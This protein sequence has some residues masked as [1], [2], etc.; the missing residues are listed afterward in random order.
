MVQAPIYHSSWHHGFTDWDMRRLLLLLVA[1]SALCA[2][3]INDGNK[4]TTDINATNVDAELANLIDI[5]WE[6][7]GL[8]TGIPYFNA[9]GT[10]LSW[11]F[12]NF[13]F[14]G[15]DMNNAVWINGSQSTSALTTEVTQLL[16][17]CAGHSAN[18]FNSND[19]GPLI[20]F[21]MQYGGFDIIA[22]D[23]PNE[24][25]ENLP[26]E[27]FFAPIVL[28]LNWALSQR[29]YDNV[30]MSGIS[31]GGWTTAVYAAFDRR[32]TR[33]VPVAGVWPFYL[34]F[35]E[36]LYPSSLGDHEQQ[37][38]NITQNYMDLFAMALA[39]NRESIHVFNSDDSCCFAGGDG[40]EY[41]DEIRRAGVSLNG[42]FGMEVNINT[43]HTADPS[44]WPFILN[45]WT[46]RIIT[47]LLDDAP[48]TTVV[49]QLGVMTATSSGSIL[50]QQPPLGTTDGFS[51]YMDDSDDEIV[52]DHEVFEGE[53]YGMQYAIRFS[54]A[55][56]TPAGQYGILFGIFKGGSPFAGPT[57][58]ANTAKSGAADPSGP[59]Q[60]RDRSNTAYAVATPTG[61][62][63][64]GVNRTWVFQ[65]R[66]I[67][68]TPQHMALE[69]FMATPG[70]NFTF[71]QGLVLPDVD[72][73]NTFD[74][75]YLLSRQTG[76]DQGNK[77]YFDNM[78]YMVGSAYDPDVLGGFAE[79]ATVILELDDAFEVLDTGDN[80]NNSHAV[81]DG[82]TLNVT[83]L[84]PD[85]GTSAYFNESDIQCPWYHELL[86]GSR[87][88]AIEFYAAWD[89]SDAGTVFSF[90]GLQVAV[91]VPAAGQVQ[92]SQ[93]TLH[94]NKTLATNASTSFN[95]GVA[96]HFLLQRRRTRPY[97]ADQWYFQVYVDGWLVAKLELYDVRH[98]DT[99][100]TGDL[101]WGSSLG[102]SPYFAG[103]LDRLKYRV[104][105]SL[106]GEQALT[107]L[108]AE[109]VFY[110]PP[111]PI[112]YVRTGFGCDPDRRYTGR[113]QSAGVSTL[114]Y[115]GYGALC[116]CIVIGT[117]AAFMVMEA[118]DEKV[119][120]QGFG[121][122]VS[123]TVVFALTVI[124]AYAM[125]D[126]YEHRQELGETSTTGMLTGGAALS[127]VGLLIHFIPPHRITYAL[128]PLMV[129]A[130]WGLLVPA[131]YLSKTP[132]G[133]FLAVCGGAAAAQALLPMAW[134]TVLQSDDIG[135]LTNARIFL[136]CTSVASVAG[137]IC[138]LMV[139]LEGPCQL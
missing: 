102:D 51:Y 118:A 42:S 14:D 114:L 134:R 35:S 111:P 71:I 68:H 125:L 137:L 4:T 109:P 18:S 131:L 96:R 39:Y 32:V 66:I 98:M 119:P 75:G 48:G 110:R 58:F 130:G 5:M 126:G 82:V 21:V 139:S 25:H 116:S 59:I 9:S 83:G 12:Y 128:G 64:D 86:P 92:L 20:D 67:G 60:F 90:A 103:T 19:G 55:Y 46:P 47:W 74:F 28:A 117:M 37:L 121:L 50:K 135:Y 56:T 73:H 69:I 27:R 89:T 65:R 63:N 40:E 6:G 10:Y 84:A 34:R 108:T 17:W 115:I 44:I 1:A 77:G 105:Y 138:A 93:S 16:I 76:V 7:A 99:V 95:D 136:F 13:T 113:T 49:D 38:P 24:N 127:V 120:Y 33:S 43:Q 3:A 101:H 26:Y 81:G 45:L 85:N 124:P 87:E 30:T 23:M 22:V 29:S 132:A 11:D 91:N 88:Y 53:P 112:Q 62:Y 100:A 36:A 8:P 61:G 72:N 133:K 122:F 104:G 52:L 97:P 15:V 107:A 70:N 57:V 31:G 80:L 123:G 79:H 2:S 129:V 94:A 54:A 106:T 41:V 78:Y